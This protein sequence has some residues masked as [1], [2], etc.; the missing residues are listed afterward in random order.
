[1]LDKL[2]AA[3]SEALRI[4]EFA[5]LLKRQVGEPSFETVDEI[6]PFIANEVEKFGRIIDDANIRTE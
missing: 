3:V 1:M 6:G 2:N 5:D 4:P